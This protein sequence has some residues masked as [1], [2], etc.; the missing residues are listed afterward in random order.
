MKLKVKFLI[1]IAIILGAILIFGQN[2]AEAYSKRVIT[3]GMP[4]EDSL[5]NIPD[6]INL[7]IMESELEKV[8]E[9]IMEKVI[10]EL[11]KQGIT[12]MTELDYWYDASDKYMISVWFGNLDDEYVSWDYINSIYKIKVRI[13]EGYSSKTHL[14]NREITIKY[15]NTEN[16]NEEDKNY[17]TEFIENFN[18][19]YPV[20]YYYVKPNE[21]FEY[22]ENLYEI[23]NDSSI[24]L[25]KNG[26][27]ACDM[28]WSQTGYLV[29]KDEVCYDWM[30]V[31]TETYYLTEN[32]NIGNNMTVD[33]LLEGVTIT[34]TPKENSD[35]RAEISDLGYEKILGEYELTL[36]GADNLAT[37]IDITLNVGTEYNGKMACVLH[38]KKDGINEKFEERVVDG[39]IKIT[40]S[41]LS[42]FVVAVKEADD[43]LLGDV[44]GNGEINAQDA[45]MILK[46]V[47]H[48][49]ELN[50]QQLLAANTTKDEDGTVD[51]QDAVQILK[52]VAHNITEF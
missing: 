46:Y 30:K 13:S 10:S 34:V 43:Y 1:M 14:I 49:I 5:N 52:L 37:P 4:T 45:V 3:E 20:L 47:A 42:P 19:Q 12:T 23:I 11:E 22:I 31:E 21:D 9:L 51:A 7:D 41:E 29:F 32:V 25:V 40:V 38:K 18:K 6:T 44:D 8:P 33:G 15:N 35:M 36:V 50:E 27:F 24:S 48:N 17:V 26:A 28:G 39:K 16:Y 2:K